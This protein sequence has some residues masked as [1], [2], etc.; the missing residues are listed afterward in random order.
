[1]KVLHLTLKRKWF[2]MVGNGKSEEYRELT[3]FWASRL[4]YR[5]ELPSAIGGF[6]SPLRDLAEGNFDFKNWKEATGNAPVFQ[7][8]THVN[9][10]N[11]YSKTSPQKTF[12]FKGIE[13]REGNPSWGA[14]PGKKYFVIK[15]GER[16]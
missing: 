13:I 14:E 15:L 12:E 11:G 10:R 6:L 9:F 7:E 1:M 16:V 2:E 4:F 3:A 8:F 5:I